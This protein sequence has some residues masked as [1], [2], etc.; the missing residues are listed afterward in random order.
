MNGQ[1]MNK[2][3]TPAL[4]A[5]GVIEFKGNGLGGGTARVFT[6]APTAAPAP[7]F[8]ETGIEVIKSC[9]VISEPLVVTIS[10][11]VRN[12]INILMKHFPGTEWLAYLVGNKD[13]R[14][15]DDLVIPKQRVTTVN[16]FVDEGVNVPIIGVIHSHHGMGN[17]FSGTDDTYINQNHDISLCI[18]D[19]GF[20]GQI[21]VKTECGRYAIVKATVVDHITDFAAD[22]FLKEVETLITKQSFY[23]P[24]QYAGQHANLTRSAQLSG[25]DMM[26]LEDSFGG[27]LGDMGSIRTY[28]NRFGVVSNVVEEA[29]AYEKNLKGVVID[30]YY[31]VELDMLVNYIESIGSHAYPLWE[32]RAFNDNNCVYTDDYYRLVDEIS[33]Y[34]DELTER[35]VVALNK[36]A[37]VLRKRLDTSV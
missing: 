12:K 9:G 34:S 5:Q 10:S 4:N 21:R 30:D 15:I 11:K 18:S 14:F 3:S 27:D 19:D 26:D 2:F 22:E 32:D 13:L 35:E 1:N 24:Y 7:S 17:G 37:V 31:K 23:N 16:V 25:I 29:A 33:T 36:L 6:P 8:W 28:N 20:N